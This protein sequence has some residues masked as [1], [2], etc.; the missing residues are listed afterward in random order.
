MTANPWRLDATASANALQILSSCRLVL[1]PTHVNVDADGLSSPLAMMHALRQMGV[2]AVPIIGDDVAPAS[3]SFLPGF[4]HVLVYGEEP[5]PDY[6]A[7]CIIDCADRRRL[8]KFYEDDPARVDSP[9][10]PIVNIDH[11]VTNDRFGT[12]NIVEP[13]AASA[14]EI[15]T[16]VLAS[17]GTE[18]NRDI[19]QCLLSGIYGDT[20][21]LR[22]DSTTSRTLRTTADLIDAGAS[23]TPIVDALFRIKPRSTV[24]LWES[25]LRGVRYT[26][27]LIWTEITP[28]ILS[29]CGAQASEAEGFVNFLL[30]TEGSRVAAI[31]YANDSGWR[32]SLRSM[33]ADVDVAAIAATF[34]G[35]GHPRAAGC[36]VKGG[37]PEREAFVTRVAKLA[38]TD[39][40]DS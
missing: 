39:V 5:L 19:A 8:G 7:L 40:T 12:V 31:L 10:V 21:G 3:L 28:E 22:T 32:V 23:P 4:E 13:G 17:W 26:G 9:A 37:S 11:H 6:D 30:G 20:L 25:A 1:M 27:S 18:L 2:E 14:S 29:E 35:G 24:C 34:G 15:V 38:G 33:A 36:S 16:D